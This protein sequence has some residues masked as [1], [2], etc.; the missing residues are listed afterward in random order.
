M[1]S[2][3]LKQ[4]G[5]ENPD[6]VIA[7]IGGGSNAAGA[8]YHYLNNEDV[9]LIG[10]EASGKGINTGYTAAT[11]TI[12]KPGIIHGSKTYLMQ[13]EDGSSNQGIGEVIIAKHRNGALDSVRMRFVGQFARFENMEEAYN[14]TG[15]DFN[16][17]SLSSGMSASTD[18]DDVPRTITLGSS[19]NKALDDDFSS[20]DEVP[21]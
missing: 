11:L 10:V 3:L 18:F 8:F 19:M 12:G 16:P 1:K 17:T 9:Q 2:Q 5:K 21:F 6:Y 4:V 14:T 7:C 15:G 20:S 13:N